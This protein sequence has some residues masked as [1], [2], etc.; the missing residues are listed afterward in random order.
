MDLQLMSG[1]MVEQLVLN[2]QQPQ[3]QQP[4]IMLCNVRM[5]HNLLMNE[6][7]ALPAAMAGQR[8]LILEVPTATTTRLVHQLVAAGA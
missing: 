2:C 8:P 3:Q 5:L 7:H 4:G 6:C 1:P